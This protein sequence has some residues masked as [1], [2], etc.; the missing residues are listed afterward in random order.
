MKKPYGDAIETSLNV[1]PLQFAQASRITPQKGDYAT[2]CNITVAPVCPFY[3][4]HAPRSFSLH[5]LHP[6]TPNQG[7]LKQRQLRYSSHQGFP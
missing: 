7:S 3:R 2:L 5:S 4:A 1:L 6:V